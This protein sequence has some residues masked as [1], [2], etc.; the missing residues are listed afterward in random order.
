V[1]V[2]DTEKLR[3]LPD[4]ACPL[5]SQNKHPEKWIDSMHLARYRNWLLV[6]NRTNREVAV[7][8]C[9]ANRFLGRLVFAAEDYFPQDLLV[10]GETIYLTVNDQRCLYTIDGR[11]LEKAVGQLLRDATKDEKPFELTLTTDDPARK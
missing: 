10:V 5:R 4:L 9:D 8:D 3:L 1:R 2:V 7:V 6:A 11:A